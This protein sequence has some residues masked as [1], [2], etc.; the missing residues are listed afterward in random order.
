[1]DLLQQKSFASEEVQLDE[2]QAK[3]H[4][5]SKTNEEKNLGF[6]LI[7]NQ[8]NKLGVKNVIIKEKD[9]EIENLN[10]IAS[11]NLV[12]ILAK[13]SLVKNDANFS[14]TVTV[15]DYSEIPLTME[16]MNKT[17]LILDKIEGKF[18]EKNELNQKL[19]KGGNKIKIENAIQENDLDEKNKDLEDSDLDNSIRNILENYK[20]SLLEINC[21][22]NIEKLATLHLNEEEANKIEKFFKNKYSIII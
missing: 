8:K 20:L 1:L 7:S 22:E 19:I 3:I 15:S 16:F 14:V 11:K 13:N 21:K 6:E 10:K 5:S 9:E 12:N 2:S 17:N 4:K 18:E